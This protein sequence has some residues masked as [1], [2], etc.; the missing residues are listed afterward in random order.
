MPQVPAKRYDVFLTAFEKEVTKAQ[1]RIKKLDRFQRVYE[2]CRLA[3]EDAK[4]ENETK[5]LLQEEGVEVVIV[6]LQADK[7]GFYSQI[8]KDIGSG[9]LQA[10]L[11]STGEAAFGTT[12]YDF[13]HKWR[14]VKISNLATVQVR[15]DVP[16]TGTDFIDF[17]K[18]I[19]KTEHYISQD[20]KPIWLKE[21]KNISAD[22]PV[23]IPF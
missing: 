20:Q 22:Q 17:E 21:P 5:L 8:I 19:P 14:L 1:E 16:F 11:H 12:S 13:C 3:L 18:G 4:L 2:I 6:P 7:E 9:L 23:E 10:G 15:I